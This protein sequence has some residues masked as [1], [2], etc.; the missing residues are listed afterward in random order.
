[1]KPV[2]NS[3]SPTDLHFYSVQE[4][5]KKDKIHYFSNFLGIFVSQLSIGAAQQP[6]QNTTH[7]T[8]ER[9]AAL[10]SECMY[11]MIISVNIDET[12][13]DR[14]KKSLRSDHIRL[15]DKLFN[16]VCASLNQLYCISNNV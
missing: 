11:D 16:W 6:L 4:K 13:P 15:P 5:K 7:L 8:L 9:A 2:E 3:F 12:S 10:L 1:M 14:E